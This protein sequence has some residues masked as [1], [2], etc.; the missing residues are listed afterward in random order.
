MGSY[1]VF[2]DCRLNRVRMPSLPDGQVLFPERYVV[3]SQTHM[4]KEMG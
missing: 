2:M 1:V 4:E 3:G